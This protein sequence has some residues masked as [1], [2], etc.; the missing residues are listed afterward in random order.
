MAHAFAQ[1][2]SLPDIDDAAEPIAHQVNAR[3][4]GQRADLFANVFGRCRPPLSYMWKVAAG[5][6]GT[7]ARQSAPTGTAS[8]PS[9]DNTTRGPGRNASMINERRLASTAARNGSP[10]FDKP[11]PR[12]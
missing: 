11:P 6:L 10:T 12:M 3:L 4:M 9:A 1:V 5:K 8:S 2:P 7:A